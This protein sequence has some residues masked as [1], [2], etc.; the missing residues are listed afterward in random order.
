MTFIISEYL[1]IL[2][3]SMFGHIEI[4]IITDILEILVNIENNN[5]KHLSQGFAVHCLIKDY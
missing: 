5:G 3:F 4:C 2:R 1:V